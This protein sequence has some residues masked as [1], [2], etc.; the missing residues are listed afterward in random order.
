MDLSDTISGVSEFKILSA[1]HKHK[2]SFSSIFKFIIK[3]NYNNRY[4]DNNIIPGST[5]HTTMFIRK[6][7]F[8]CFQY[9]YH[10][11]VFKYHRIW[12]LIRAAYTFCML[13]HL[14]DKYLTALPGILFIYCTE[15]LSCVREPARS[16][17]RR[18]NAFPAPMGE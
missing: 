17:V 16:S 18:R 13:I 3:M 10:Y 15:C 7:I 8:Y 12:V 11:R 2:S 14:G 9:I 6:V 4:Y 5:D 1:F